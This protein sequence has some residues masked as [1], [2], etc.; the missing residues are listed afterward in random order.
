MNS[1]WS[2]FFDDFFAKFPILSSSFQQYITQEYLKLFSKTQRR[3]GRKYLFS[4]N[5]GDK[6]LYK[7]KM[8]GYPIIYRL[9]A[10]NRY[11]WPRVTLTPPQC[12][13]QLTFV[14]TVN[15]TRNED[16]YQLNKPSTKRIRYGICRIFISPFLF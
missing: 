2:I 5:V 15:N 4:L 1:N 7:V 3:P 12:Q 10:V 14:D 6:V 13:S 9:R 11:I 8:I 16:F